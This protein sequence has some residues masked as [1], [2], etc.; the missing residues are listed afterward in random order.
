[1]FDATRREETDVQIEERRRGD[2]FVLDLHGKL[3]AGDG[4]TL[5]TD[6][7]RRFAAQRVQ[8]V[9]LNFADVP[10]MDSLGVSAIVRSHLALRQGGGQL[11]LLHLPRRIADLFTATGLT[12]VFETFDE[13]SDAI[14]SFDGPSESPIDGR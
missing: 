6:T 4:D 10:Y 7:L 14:A 9:L 5:L 11:K 3:S 13:E 2:V 1:V 12:A 8:K